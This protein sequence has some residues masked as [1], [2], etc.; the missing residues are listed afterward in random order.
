LWLARE[1]AQFFAAQ[2][3]VEEGGQDGAIA[4]AFQRV[5]RGRFQQRPDLAV[6]QRRRLAPIV[7]GLGALDP[8][9]RVVADGIGLAEVVEERGDRGEFS[10]D[11]TRG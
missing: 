4:F 5:R 10:A 8:A 11:G 1:A 2:P 3:V 7:I 6:A 9:D